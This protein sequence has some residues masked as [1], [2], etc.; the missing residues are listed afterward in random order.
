MPVFIGQVKLTTR[1][2]CLL[3]LPEAKR[4]FSQKPSAGPMGSIVMGTLCTAT[5][6]ATFLPLQHLDATSGLFAVLA[7]ADKECKA[8]NTSDLLCDQIVVLPRLLTY[9]DQKGDMC[10]EHARIY[11]RFLA[12]HDE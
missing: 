4:R 8:S 10:Y 12:L 3:R 7:D 5:I 11:C 1:C 6:A 9:N 2:Q